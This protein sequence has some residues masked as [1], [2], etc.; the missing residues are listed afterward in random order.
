M[1][2]DSIIKTQFLNLWTS[3]LKNFSFSSHLE[4]YLIFIPIFIA[5][6]LL[7]FL[8]TPIIGNL[9]KKHNIVYVPN[10]KRKG[11]DFDNSDKALHKGIIPALGGLAVMIPVFLLMIF[12]FKLDSITLPLLVALGI[13]TIGG[14]LDDIFN[15]PAKTQMILQV[16]AASVIVFSI[17]D[18][19]S[20]PLLNTTIPMD[21]LKFQPTIGSF[22]FSLVFPG[23][24]FLFIW[25]VFCINSFKWMGGS[26]GLI[27]GTGLIT[28]ALIFIISIR[29]QVLFSSTASAL[30]TGSLLAFLIFAYPPPLIMSG[31]SGKSVYGLLI[32]SL[33]L[34]SQTKFATTLILLLFPTLDAAY[35]LIKRY[36]EYKPRNFLSLMKISG[37]THFHHQLLKLDLSRRNVFW[38]EILITLTI[39]SLVIITTG[40]YRYFFIILGVTLSLFLILYT[41]F[42]ASKKE[43]AES[44]RKESSESK[45]SY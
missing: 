21:I 30:I 24:L 16:I 19:D 35:V 40:A 7:S 20:L 32:C 31:S 9:A 18:L 2:D 3:L 6:F 11:K 44:N 13:L 42:K 26:P 4:K 45:Y 37:T 15:L 29:Y 41:N 22:A 28:T 27:E 5:G 25:L 39:G 17:L 38:V 43:S 36:V 10:I 33:G 8:L 23:D 34:I 1:T 14:I 12:C